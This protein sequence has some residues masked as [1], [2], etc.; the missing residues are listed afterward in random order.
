MLKCNSKAKGSCAGGG[1]IMSLDRFFKSIDIPA[2]IHTFRNFPLVSTADHAANS[3][4]RKALKQVTRIPHEH[5]LLV[6]SI[7]PTSRSKELL[8]FLFLLLRVIPEGHTIG[9][10]EAL[11]LMFGLFRRT[12]S[13]MDYENRQKVNETRYI[14][15]SL[16]VQSILQKLCTMML[17]DDE[18][19]AHQFYYGYCELLHHSI[20]ID[21][22]FQMSEFD[23]IRCHYRKILSLVLGNAGNSD[24]W[25]VLKEFLSNLKSHVIDSRYHTEFDEL[26]LIARGGF[27]SVF[28]ACNKLDGQ[29]YAVKKINIT[30]DSSDIFL[31]DLREV[32]ILASLNH[33]HIVPYK[34]A[35]LELQPTKK[36]STSTGFLSVTDGSEGTAVT[37]DTQ[38]QREEFVDSLQNAPPLMGWQ[39]FTLYIQMALCKP[40]LREFLD[41]RNGS[42][43]IEHFYNV[44]LHG[45]INWE[46]SLSSNEKEDNVAE[47]STSSR[48]LISVQHLDIVLETIMQLLG[49]LSYLHSRGIVHH[50]IKP[51]NIFIGLCE[52]II[53]VQL[54]DFGL[55]CLSRCHMNDG[56]GTPPYAAPEQLDSKCD[57]KSDIYSLGIILLELLVPFKTITERYTE[58][59]NTR[60]GN[61][62]KD[63]GTDFKALLL[64]MLQEQPSSRLAIHESLEKVNQMR[65]SRTPIT[66][67][68]NIKLKIKVKQNEADLQNKE[69]QLQAK[70]KE[71]KKLR[72]KLRKSQM[73]W[74]AAACKTNGKEKDK[75]NRLHS[76]KSTNSIFIS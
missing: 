56:C 76:A 51:A 28:K 60:L 39:E 52:S 9:S 62:P 35:W 53:N 48:D 49:G 26:D 24:I 33:K 57:S 3:K 2:M 25:I 16:M 64:G 58:I 40:T 55:S 18:R 65:T 72:E 30:L 13:S 29:E 66:I 22:T 70:D 10:P 74:K 50:D 6:E 19:L 59:R 1:R 54:A 4:A 46:R 21:K 7:V 73:R 61:C 14:Y 15:F 23:M 34:A 27:G 45:K 71:I 31:K 69:Q 38:S 37:Q 41:Y 44:F 20:L 12:R 32:K 68:E 8:V 67:T 17:P 43:N 63:V 5:K 75:I 36:R 11:L 47:E 42:P